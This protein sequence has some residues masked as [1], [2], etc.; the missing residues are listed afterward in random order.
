ME[1][2]RFISC[3]TTSYN[4]LFIRLWIATNSCLNW[5][6]LILMLTLCYT[7][8]ILAPSLIYIFTEKIPLVVKDILK[9]RSAMLWKNLPGHL[10]ECRSLSKVKATLKAHLSLYVDETL[11]F[12]LYPLNASLSSSVARLQHIL[13]MHVVYF[14]MSLCSCVFFSSY[15]FS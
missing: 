14:F 10:K 12:E 2:Y 11:C 9:Y 6:K 5:S 4:Y 13:R 1:L 8:T 3:M 15:W 7:R